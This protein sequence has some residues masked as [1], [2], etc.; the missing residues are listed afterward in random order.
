MKPSLRNLFRKKFTRDRVV[1]LECGEQYRKLLPDARLEIVRG[2]GHAVDLEAPA[3]LAELIR[4]S[5]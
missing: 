3:A 5:R 2:C 1:P 4:K